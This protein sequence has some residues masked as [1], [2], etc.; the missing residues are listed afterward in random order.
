MVNKSQV[1]GLGR[2]GFLRVLAVPTIGI[3]SLFCLENCA[4][5]SMPEIQRVNA[6]TREISHHNNKSSK[7]LDNFKRDMDKALELSLE[8]SVRDIE[9]SGGYYFVPQPNFFYTPKGNF[10]ADVPNDKR[11]IPIYLD[12]K[13]VHVPSTRDLE[14]SIDTAM[15][16]Q[17]MN[18]IPGLDGCMMSEEEIES[19]VD[20]DG[21]KVQFDTEKFEANSS[22]SQKDAKISVSLPAEL[23]S[24]R[25]LIDQG[26]YDTSVST[27]CYN[28]WSTA[29]DITNAQTKHE[30]M[31][32]DEEV[33]KLTE[34]HEIKS[35]R[36]KVD[37]SPGEIVIYHLVKQ[38][39]GKQG[40]E[41]FSF[42][43]DL[44]R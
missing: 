25:A 20:I 4:T 44:R 18:N 14:K 11:Y 17:V 28:L 21:F 31:L 29:L 12:S 8:G 38:N 42:A 32:S 27:N 24:N 3:A 9:L 26:K 30:E 10:F 19:G 23:R 2:R 43:H 16:Y 35:K 34:G 33:S 7:S 22:L 15:S 1:I 39:P 41:V 5:N 6:S 36:L 40:N 13:G 37:M